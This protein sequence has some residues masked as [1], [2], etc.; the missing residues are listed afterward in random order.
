MVSVHVSSHRLNLF[1]CILLLV[2]MFLMC[3][4]HF[5]PTWQPSATHTHTQCHSV[6]AFFVLMIILHSAPKRYGHVGIESQWDDCKNHEGS[7][8]C[9]QLVCRQLQH[10]QSLNTDCVGWGWA[11]MPV[12]SRSLHT[13]KHLNLA[14]ILVAKWTPSDV[15][16]I[17]AERSQQHSDQ[18]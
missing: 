4:P 1:R 5:P 11:V 16:I 3:Y 12:S 6:T 2:V 14:N 13:S 15:M 17:M 8:S 9:W 10:K 7:N 18:L